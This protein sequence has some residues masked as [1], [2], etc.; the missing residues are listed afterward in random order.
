M[1]DFAVRFNRQTVFFSI[2]KKFHIQSEDFE[3]DIVLLML[4]IDS[5]KMGS[6][7]VGFILFH[8]NHST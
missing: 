1:D 5:I 7:D 2:S 3:R 6:T 4:E 8:F